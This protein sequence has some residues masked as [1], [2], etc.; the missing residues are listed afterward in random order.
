MGLSTTLLSPQSCSHVVRTRF[1]LRIKGHVRY[2]LIQTH[3]PLTNTGE[4]GWI[5]FSAEFYTKIEMIRM[6][7]K[8]ETL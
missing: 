5:L 2:S 6:N 8:P 4:L 7:I 3:I 1:L